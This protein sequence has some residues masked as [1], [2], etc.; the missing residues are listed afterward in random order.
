M[1]KSILA[2]DADAAQSPLSEA[3]PPRPCASPARARCRPPPRPRRRRGRWAA[4]RSRATRRSAGTRGRPR[5]TNPPR[6]TEAPPR[7]ETSRPTTRSP[8]RPRPTAR[9]RTVGRTRAAAAKKTQTT[10]GR[11]G[12]SPRRSRPCRDDR[13]APRPTSRHRRCRSPHRCACAPTKP[14]GTAWRP[15]AET[16]ASASSTRS[17]RTARPAKRT[18]KQTHTG[19]VHII[20]SS[21]R[22]QLRSHLGFRQGRSIRLAGFLRGTH[23]LSKTGRP[24]INLISVVILAKTPSGLACLG[25]GVSVL[26]R[27]PSAAAETSAHTLGQIWDTF[28]SVGSESFVDKRALWKNTPDAPA[29]RDCRWSTVAGI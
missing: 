2:S 15:T 3:A 7:R 12:R 14:R 21:H 23:H 10:T 17:T 1:A 28:Q 5:A 13:A 29:K 26:R 18:H 24:K 11:R 22:L 9:N 27:R 19:I 6:P 4:S 16:P 25:A 8:G 20:C